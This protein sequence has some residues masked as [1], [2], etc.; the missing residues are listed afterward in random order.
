MSVTKLGSKMMP[1]CTNSSSSKST[2]AFRFNLSWTQVLVQSKMLT[3]GK[4]RLKYNQS[5][6]FHCYRPCSVSFHA[7]RLGHESRW[8]ASWCYP[9]P[10][11]SIWEKPLWALSWKGICHR[12][13]MDYGSTVQV[14]DWLTGMPG[15]KAECRQT[16]HSMGWENSSTAM[17]LLSCHPASKQ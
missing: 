11:E 3:N 9:P 8:W 4:Y 14:W 16:L 5:P 7:D 17:P 1:S 10:Q 12:R 6:R 13:A 2:S 15:S